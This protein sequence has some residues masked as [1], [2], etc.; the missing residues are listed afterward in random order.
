MWKKD[1]G[2]KAAAEGPIDATQWLWQ[3]HNKVNARLAESDDTTI[4]KKQWPAV[5]FCDECYTNDA[6]GIVEPTEHEPNPPSQ[7]PSISTV[8]WQPN[9]WS[10]GNVFVYH[11]EVYCYKSDTWAC[12]QFYDPSL[13]VENQ[14]AFAFLWSSTAQIVLLVVLLCVLLGLCLL[15]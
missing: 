2:R 7:P 8:H 3:A 6:R 1:G 14:S 4:G 13:A 10:L 5:E 9:Q 12:S 15:G 11:Q